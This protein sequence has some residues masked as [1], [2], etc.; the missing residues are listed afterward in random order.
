[1][2]SMRSKSGRRPVRRTSRLQVECLESRHLP[3]ASPLPVLEALAAHATLDAAQVLGNLNLDNLQVI[4]SVTAS[5]E[6]DWYRFTLQNASALTLSASDLSFGG[7]LSLYVSDVNTPLGHRLVAQDDGPLVQ[8]LS[9]GTYH[10]AVSG[11]G[12]RWFHPFLANSGVDGDVGGYGLTLA[13]QPL[14]TTGLA[15]LATNPAEGAVLFASPLVLNATFNAAVNPAAV[16]LGRNVRLLYSADGNFNSGNVQQVRLSSFRTNDA[17]CELQLLPAAPLRP[18]FYQLRIDLGAS[19][20]RSFRIGG[21]EG[22]AQNASDGTLAS[23]H[24]LGDLTNSGIRIAGAIS[25]DPNDSVRFNPADVD[26][27]RFTISGPGRFALVGEVF[28]QRLGSALDAGLSLYS[29]GSNG[30]LNLI[31]SNDNSRNDLVATNGTLP[32]YSDPIL[33]SGLTAGEYC[34]GVSSGLAGTAIGEYLLNIAVTS[35]NLRPLV[36]GASL[37]EGATLTAPPTYFTIQFSEDVN[38]PQLAE[39]GSEAVVVVGASGQRFVPRLVSWDSAT[40][41]ATFLMLDG[42][43]N[44]AYQLQLAGI[45]DGAGNAL[46]DW[47]L[48]FALDGP[49]RG[50]V[51]NPLL[52]TSAGFNHDLLLAQNLGILFPN[53]LQFRAGVTV[54]RDAGRSDGPTDSADFY[55]FEVLQGRSYFFT[56]NSAT[57]TNGNALSIFDANGDPVAFTTSAQGRI[58]KSILEPG[59]YVLRVGGWSPETAAATSYQIK[60]TLGGAGENPTPL[61]AGPAPVLRIRLA[62]APPPVAPLAIPTS[63]PAPTNRETATLTTLPAGAL[64]ALAERPLGGTRG[65]ALYSTRPGEA[66]AVAPPAP[67]SPS[68][69]VRS[70]LFA[71]ADINAAA[72]DPVPPGNPTIEVVDAFF[73]PEVVDLPEDP[74]AD[75]SAPQE[76]IELQKQS[77]ATIEPATEVRGD[78]EQP[79]AVETA[80]VPGPVWAWVAALATLGAFFSARW[81]RQERAAIESRRPGN[82][83]TIE[84]AREKT[85]LVK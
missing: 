14:V 50:S 85:V 43:A 78:S 60:F 37:S 12:N 17:A 24:P 83:R 26:L 82:N 53:E 74:V 49:V 62:D 59:I 69:V 34:L 4:G 40:H 36:V 77:V 66:F 84:R 51:G 11:A 68:R 46:A 6:V 79:P 23:A 48:N 8:N 57:V 38:L 41:R 15:V 28:A 56:L 44:G 67:V 29:V 10:L 30:Q 75:A 25:D 70:S 54:A 1:M 33:M 80:G 61:T 76:P 31:A 16:S 42:L 27:Y 35:D 52:W 20:T 47:Q 55:R 39:Q 21:V 18:G 58:L 7:V 5:T 64:T 71:V 45:S 19:F 9:A 3:S 73:G 32:L 22:L 2:R 13:A 65:E 72:T 63:N 81:V